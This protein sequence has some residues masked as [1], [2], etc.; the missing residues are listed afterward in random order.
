VFTS[1]SHPKLSPYSRNGFSLLPTVKRCRTLILKTKI[2]IVSYFVILKMEVRILSVYSL[3]PNQTPSYSASG[4]VTRHLIGIQ[5]VCKQSI[6]YE[7]LCKTVKSIEQTWKSSTN[8]EQAQQYNLLVG[9][10]PMKYLK[11][12]GMWWCV[13]SGVLQEPSQSLQ[14]WITIDSFEMLGEIIQ[15]YHQTDKSCT[16]FMCST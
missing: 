10:K 9:R 6:S 8:Q 7:L 1:S 16:T 5:A 12:V 4:R 3:N 2:E 11:Q 14:E 13:I 15:S